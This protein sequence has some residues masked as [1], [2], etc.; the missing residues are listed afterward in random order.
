MSD[1]LLDIEDEHKLTRE[2]AAAKL[3]ELADQLS[4]HNEVSFVR[5]GLPFKVKVP[6]EVEFSFE[7]EIGEES[8]IEIEIS[9]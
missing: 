1:E 6:D 4:R 7:V 2:E 8:E 5:G 3:R 9:W